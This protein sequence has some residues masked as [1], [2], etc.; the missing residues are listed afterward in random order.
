MIKMTNLTNWTRYSLNVLMIACITSIIVDVVVFQYLGDLHKN[1]DVAHGYAAKLETWESFSALFMFVSYVVS[2]VMVLKWIYAANQNS[3]HLGANNMRFS[4]GWSIGWYFIPVA[5]LWKPYQAMKE[6]WKTSVNPA[7]WVN[8]KASSLLGWW[9]FL[10]II[11][12]ISGNISFGMFNKDNP[13]LDYLAGATLVN[14]LHC[15]LM[16]VLTMLLLAIISKIHAMQVKNVT[17]TPTS[18]IFTSNVIPAQIVKSLQLSC[19]S[20]KVKVHIKEGELLYQY[21]AFIK[22]ALPKDVIGQ[23]EAHPKQNGAFIVRNKSSETWLY[24]YDGQSYAIKPTQARALALGGK[25]RVGTAEI[26]IVSV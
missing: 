19:Q 8:E 24:E 17:L 14:I 12:S 21:Q 6:I 11:T 9:W 18:N 4:P 7:N 16:I 15:A 13:T 25:I 10:W 1:N 2:A 26:D 3:R 22:P 5:N 23:I 20:G